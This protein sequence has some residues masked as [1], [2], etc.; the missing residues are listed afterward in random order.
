MKKYQ[1]GVTCIIED[2]IVVYVEADT[3]EEAQVK[4]Q[5]QAEAQWDVLKTETQFVVDKPVEQ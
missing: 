4:A 2:F 5:T 3:P 1:V